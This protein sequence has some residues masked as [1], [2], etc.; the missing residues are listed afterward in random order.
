MHVSSSHRSAFANFRCGVAPIRPL[1]GRYEGLQ[2]SQPLCPFGCGVVE[3]E[4]RV[5]LQYPLYFHERNIMLQKASSVIG[6][7]TMLGEDDFSVHPPIYDKS[8]C[9]NLFGYVRI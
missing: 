2:E 1:T 4:L 7:F 8:C 6:N 9:K 5:L 3:S